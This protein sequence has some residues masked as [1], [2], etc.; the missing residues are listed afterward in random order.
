MFKTAKEWPRL[1]RTQER[2]SWL[3]VD[4]DRWKSESSEEEDEKE[5]EQ[6]KK[7]V[8]LLGRSNV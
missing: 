7:L 4:F 8:S 1:Q 2:P 5:K 3:R 6:S